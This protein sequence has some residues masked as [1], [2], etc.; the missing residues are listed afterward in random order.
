MYQRFDPFTKRRSRKAVA[1]MTGR[2]FKGEYRKWDA[3]K[4]RKSGPLMGPKMLRT[5]IKL[6][7]KNKRKSFLKV[8]Y[9]GKF[10]FNKRHAYSV[11]GT[12]GMSSNTRPWN[13]VA[14]VDGVLRYVNRYGKP[15]VV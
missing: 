14:Y 11:G 1:F 10:T 2:P 8:S 5:R 15:A 9:P 6:V 7:G 13:A 12:R 3:E 4:A